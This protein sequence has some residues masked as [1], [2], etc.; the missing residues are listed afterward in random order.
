MQMNSF[1]AALGRP[2]APFYSLAMRLREHLY[3]RGVFRTHRLGVPVISVGNL[4]MG[5][6]GKTPMVQYLA[7]LLQRYGHHPAVISRGYGG[8][9]RQP[10]NLVSDGTTLLLNAHEAGDEP[11][12]LAETLP[13]VP[14]LTGVVRHMPA[15]RALEMGA[16]VL[17]L[18]DGF[19]HMA[20]ARDVN[21]ALF[22]ADHLAGNSRVFPG[23]ELREPVAALRRATA[24]VLTGVREDNRERAGRFGELLCSRF[25]GIPVELTGFVPDG[26]VQLSPDGMLEETDPSLLSR[27]GWFAFCGIA[28]PERFR[29]TLESAGINVVGMESLDD[30]QRYTEA[31]IER[32]AAHAQRAGAEGLL[33]TEKDLVKLGEHRAALSLPVAALRMRVSADP[34][35]DDLVLKPWRTERTV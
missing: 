28:H 35:F 31:V 10:V 26:L 11:R 30:H 34:S 27:Q 21:L 6:T 32:L 19:Q 15:R 16:D 7:R 5:G 1:Y 8:A 23:G 29:R 4:T 12:L 13:G 3:R 24:F 20:V 9:S 17:V 14:V 18:D 25:P 22:N 33:T 2:F